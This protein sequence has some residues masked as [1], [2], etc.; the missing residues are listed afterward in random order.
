M[1]EDGFKNTK[2]RMLEL[3]S[4]LDES[5]LKDVEQW[6]TSQSYKKDLDQKR[7]LLNLEKN[8]LKIGNTIKKIVPFD[9]EMTSENIVPPKIGDQSDCNK[10]N[11][12]HVDEFLYDDDEVEKLVKVGKL[13]R[14]YCLECNSRNVKELMYISHS[15]SRQALQ[16]IFKV[17]LPKDLEDKQVLDV[18][19]RLGAVIYGAYYFS[20]AGTIIGIEMNKECCEVQERIINQYSMDNNRI[21]VIS[22]DV[23][24]RI[25]VVTSSDVIIINILDFFVDSEKHKNMWY[26]FKKHIKKGSYIV[27]NRNMQET[28][29]NLDVVEEFL[30]WLSVCKPNQ[31]ENEVFFDI[32]D[33]SDLYLYAVN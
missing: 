31:L 7:T 3:F 28:L 11:T 10:T 32:E 15:M 4:E 2:S 14:H 12:C 17:L 21:K 6:I 18:G 33:C 1:S 22:S 13:K 24:E 27:C 8:L 30:N 23:M 29:M 5:E 26:F 19:S 20:N 25:D 16:Y 9:A